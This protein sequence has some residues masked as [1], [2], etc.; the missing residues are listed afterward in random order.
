[1]INNIISGEYK[2]YMK[3]YNYYKT[4]TDIVAKNNDIYNKFKCDELIPLEKVPLLREPDEGMRYI[5]QNKNLDKYLVIETSTSFYWV[6]TRLRL[7]E[8]KNLD[9][10]VSKYLHDNDQLNPDGVQKKLFVFSYIEGD[11]L[12]S[13]LDKVDKN[14]A[15]DL[16]KQL[17][18]ILKE[19]HSVKVDSLIH[20]I[21]NWKNRYAWEIKNIIKEYQ[22]NE[23][24]DN[25][26]SFYKNNS[27]L[28]DIYNKSSLCTYDE[29]GKV[30]IENLL[31]FINGEIK[32]ENLIVNNGKI[33]VKSSINI[34]I[35]DPVYD[36]K[37]L[38]LIALENEYFASG[39]INGYFNENVPK[40]FFEMLKF[41][42]SELIITGYNKTL[43]KET[44]S[45]ILYSYDDFNIDIPKWYNN[46]L[47]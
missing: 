28:I 25:A 8:I 42:T 22:S 47:I 4:I 35:T 7:Y 36:F 44:I 26:Y 17:A 21:V 2:E 31:S 20:H 34:D 6:D 23:L 29:N 9:I 10:N 40:R 3:D 45:K 33:G 32:P 5:L 46:N 14:V 18:R 16:G 15:Y 13:Y 41:Y 39:I 27:N 37:Y 43:T 19:I 38:S 11:S 1:M 30:I 12:K 24:T